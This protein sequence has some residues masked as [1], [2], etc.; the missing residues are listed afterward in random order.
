M[1]YSETKLLIAAHEGAINALRQLTEAVGIPQP[2]TIRGGNAQAGQRRLRNG[3]TSSISRSSSTVA[4][5]I[6]AT[7][8]LPQGH[9]VINAIMN[10]SDMPCET[11]AWPPGITLI[12]P[13]RPPGF[14]GLIEATSNV[15]LLSCPDNKAVNKRTT[16]SIIRIET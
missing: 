14:I 3:S 15:S 4:R 13:P 10:L 7:G 11:N 6:T 5:K 12:P 8:P 1:D 16:V 2:G 9:M